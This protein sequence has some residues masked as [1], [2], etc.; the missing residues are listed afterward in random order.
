MLNLSDKE[1]DRLAREAA[2]EYDPGVRTSPSSWERLQQHLEKDLGQ[3]NPRFFRG[4][5]RMPFYYV[6]AA[7]LLIVGLSI[8]F[9]KQGRKG[10][11]KTPPQNNLAIADKPSR[12]GPPGSSA[13]EDATRSGTNPNPNN[14]TPSYRLNSTP[15]NPNSPSSSASPAGVGSYLS[16]HTGVGHDLS[17][18]MGKRGNARGNRNHISGG[19]TAGLQGSNGSHD[20]SNPSSGRWSAQS[21]QSSAQHGTTPGAVFTTPDPQYTAVGGLKAANLPPPIIDDAGLRHLNAQNTTK[22][23]D[24]INLG[25]KKSAA[26][27]IGRPLELGFSIAPDFA[28]V[29]TLAGDKPGSSIGLTLDYQPF[30]RW[31]IQSGLLLSR[32]NYTAAQQDY[33]ASYAYYMMNNMHDVYFIKGT[34]QL[35]ELPLNLRYDFSVSGNTMLFLSA[36]MSSYLLTHENCNYYFSRYGRDAVQGFNYNNGQAYFMS[37]VNLSA[38]LETGISNSLSLLVAP[39]AKLPTTGMGFGSVDI[40]SVGIDFSLRYAPVLKHKRH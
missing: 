25:K 14:Q 10:S 32:K 2:S 36:G 5:R 12:G 37:T 33:H 1:L 28:S 29:N 8:Y 6:P 18:A 27:R 11:I 15:Q 39:Y 26:A 9:V 4:I 40:N 13:Q 30:N 24:P 35:I 3:P 31:H 34:D 16:T 21:R 19:L 20:P 17:T 23:S 38:G 7:A 22:A